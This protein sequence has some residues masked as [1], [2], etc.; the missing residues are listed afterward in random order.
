MT[1]WAYQQK[2]PFHAR[3]TASKAIKNNIRTTELQT[4][5]NLKLAARKVEAIITKHVDHRKA[6]RD[7]NP[8]R[9]NVRKTLAER[10]LQR[11]VPED[12]SRKTSDLS[13][14]FQIPAASGF[15]CL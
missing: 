15:Y 2:L 12:D 1:D 5:P 9:F 10:C 14:E 4:D 3:S 6:E 11:P 8:E 7:E 13:I